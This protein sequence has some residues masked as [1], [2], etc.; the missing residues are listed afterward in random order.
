MDKSS[1]NKLITFFSISIYLSFFLGFYFNE[2]SSGAGNYSGDLTWMWNNFEIYKSNDLWT[3]IHHP[4]FWGNRTPLMYILHIVLNPFISDIDTYRLSVFC[5][6]FSAPL[7]FY[8][9]LLQKFKEVDKN[10][11]F[12]ISSFILLSPYFRTNSYWAGETNYGII[13]IL[14]SIYFLNHTLINNFLRIKTNIYLSLTLLTFFSSLCIYFDQKLLIIPLLVLFKILYSQIDLR[15]KLYSI[16]NYCIFSVPFLYL[17]FTWKGLIPPATQAYSPD[18]GSSLSSI[19]LH[20]FH[21]GY[22]TAIIAFYLLPIILLKSNNL[23]SSLKDFFYD[24]KNLFFILIFIIYLFFINIFYDFENFTINK[25]FSTADYG[26]YGL[27]ILHKISLFLF[28]DLFYREIFTYLV[29]FISW[30][31]LLFAIEKKTINI[32]II[33]YFYFL[34]LIIFPLMQ[35]YF[36]PYIILFSFLLFN[37]KFDFKLYKLI[38]ALVY[39]IIF[40]TGANLYYFIILS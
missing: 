9:C 22:A 14:A 33:L 39:F 5:I 3:A 34:S 1:K 26:V 29:F 13:T 6:S 8:L 11:L 38:G 32:I 2:N 19:K 21:I 31:I 35:E 4:D 18:Q 17:I 40:L 24:K 7:I 28:S 10:I 37:L 30:I 23:I 20:F 16:L 36:D 27:G 25:Q 12:F 15:Y